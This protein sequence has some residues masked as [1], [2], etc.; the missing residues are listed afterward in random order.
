MPEII[1]PNYDDLIIRNLDF[2]QPAG[3][4]RSAWTGWRQ[5]IGG[6]GA[7]LWYGEIAIVDLT[8]ELE[9]RPWRG[10]VAALDGVVKWFRLYLPCQTHIGPSP[11][12]AAGATNGKTMPLKGMQPNTC[13]LDV[14]QHLTVPL[15]SGHFRAVRLTAALI[16]DAAG[17]ATAQFRPALNEVPALNTVVGSAKPFV[18]V[19]ATDN[20]IPIVLDGGVSGFSISVEEAR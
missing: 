13:I 20:R 4:N 12:V 17:N 5:V 18:P 6:P 9:E 16:T 11:L 10:F 19:A 15:P 3:V 14:G 7:A 1:V 8:T 2:S